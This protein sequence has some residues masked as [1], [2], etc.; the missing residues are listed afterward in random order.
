MNEVAE[1]EATQQAEPV[2]TIPDTQ[3]G[4]EGR[5]AEDREELLR[6]AVNEADPTEVIEPETVPEKETPEPTPQE[7]VAETPEPAPQDTPET[8]VEPPKHQSIDEL[9]KA[10]K[11]LESKFGERS[12]ELGDLRKRV[13]ELETPPKEPPPDPYV[14]IKP[15][16]P[17]VEGDSERYTREVQTVARAE[18]AEIAKNTTK[19]V[20]QDYDQARPVNEMIANFNKAHPDLSPARVHGVALYADELANHFQKSVSLDEAFDKMYPGTGD[21]GTP[22]PTVPEK[23]K[24]IVR[25]QQVPQTIADTPAS[26]PPSDKPT[27]DPTQA[28]WDAM[29]DEQRAKALL[30][31]PVPGE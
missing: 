28:Q 18:A 17:F 21:N 27:R 14:G 20:L 29:T 15:P 13:A 7:L 5:T 6:E 25:A 9:Q 22:I 4:W 16:D 26:P 10:N 30:D 24:A 11:A 2:E 31:I 12:Q 8:P 23:T 3:E 1:P 19:E